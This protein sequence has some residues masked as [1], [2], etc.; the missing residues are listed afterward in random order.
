LHARERSNA[1]NLLAANLALENANAALK[2]SL[3]IHETLT[4]A[5]ATTNGIDGIARAVLELTGYPVAIEDRYGNLV[6]WAGAGHPDPYPKDPR[7][8]RDQLLQHA[9]QLGNPLR[10]DGRLIALARTGDH[11]FGTI[12]LIDPFDASGDT[13]RTAL[14]HGA[15]VLALEFAHL[16]SLAETQRRM[17]RDFIEDLLLGTDVGGALNRARAL[18]YDLA[19]PHR[20]VVV[21]A[22]GSSDSDEE[23]VFHAVRRAVRDLGVG[24]LLLERGDRVVVLAD[25]EPDWNSFRSAIVAELVRG[26]CRIGIGGRCL[27]AADF[28][29]S[30]HQALLALSMQQT[31]HGRRVTAYDS[32][33]VYRLFSEIPNSG[34]VE[35]LVSEWLGPLIDYDHQKGAQLV[36]TLGAYLECGGNYDATAHALSLHRSTL[37]YRLRR[38]RELSGHDLADPDTRFNL[39]LATRAWCTLTTLRDG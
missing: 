32:L 13:H 30:H 19:R 2:Q 12:A 7:S 20:V 21:E 10:Q 36:E 3:E 23:A 5:A 25:S 29:R 8:R 27:Q 4:A 24:S 26:D 18:D 9:L 37:R 14:E 39:Q 31:V 22:T 6:A 17:S 38:V 11:I 28:P 15:T 34:S 33:G 16:R 1:D 35:D